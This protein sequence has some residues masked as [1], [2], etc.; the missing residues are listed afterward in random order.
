MPLNLSTWTEFYNLGGALMHVILGLAVL[1]ALLV[2]ERTW[3]LCIGQDADPRRLMAQ[4]QSALLA[5]DTEAA[6]RSCG[7]SA[8]V[9]R[10][11][12][13]GLRHG[14]DPRRAEAAVRE[15]WFALEP[16]LRRWLPTLSSIAGLAMLVGFLGTVFGLIGGFHCGVVSA[17]ARAGAIARSISIAIH[18][19][20]FGIL[21]GV[22]L[23]SARLVLVN[24]SEK[25][26]GD[27]ALCGIKLVNLIRT[28]AAPPPGSQPAR[29]ERRG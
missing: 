1:G 3:R 14:L 25:L 2:I 17:E 26:V 13:A 12:R 15:Q 18:T 5:G 29:A 4:V 6:L 21:V 11:V 28:I 10:I 24:A 22:G 19:S 20:G 16:S 23:L 7:R 27:V 8:D 9:H